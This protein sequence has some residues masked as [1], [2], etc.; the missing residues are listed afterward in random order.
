MVGMSDRLGRPAVYGMMAGN[1]ELSGDA[2]MREMQ[3][4]QV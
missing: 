1:V 3:R 2:A 4:L